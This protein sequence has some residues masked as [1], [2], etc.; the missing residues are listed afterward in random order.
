M[1]QRLSRDGV[2]LHEFARYPAVREDNIMYRPIH[3]ILGEC[4]VYKF[5]G[6]HHGTH[7]G[8]RADLLEDSVIPAATL[9][10]AATLPIDEGRGHEKYA[11]LGKN[12]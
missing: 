4:D 1:F 3:R 7:L 8:G 2:V 11:D 12:I 10:D 6:I 9:P 5:L